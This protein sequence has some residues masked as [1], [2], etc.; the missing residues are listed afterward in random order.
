MTN[1]SVLG[2]ISDCSRLQFSHRCERMLDLR[3]HFLKQI[4][5]KFHP[6]DVE[7]ETELTIFQEVSLKSLPE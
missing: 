3:P 5:R 1:H 6:A 2:G 7:G 4:V